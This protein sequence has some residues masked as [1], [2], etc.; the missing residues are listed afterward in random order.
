[1]KPPYSNKQLKWAFA[2]EKKG[3]LPKGDAMKWA[4]RLKARKNPFLAPAQSNPLQTLKDNCKR[5]PY[6]ML[7]AIGSASFNAFLTDRLPSNFHLPFHTVIASSTLVLPRHPVTAAI[8]G[9]MFYA[10]ITET[11]QSIAKNLAS[12]K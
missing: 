7:G 1:M 11:Y 6:T 12:S 5:I 8:G 10:L 9:A 4:H 2:A 3:N